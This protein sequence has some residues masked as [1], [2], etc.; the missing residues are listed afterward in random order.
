M[1]DDVENRNCILLFP[2]F[3][4]ITVNILERATL[5]SQF[6]KLS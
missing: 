3:I 1:M 4:H 2:K 5:R 6:F